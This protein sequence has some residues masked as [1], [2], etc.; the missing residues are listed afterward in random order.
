MPY[1]LP[2]LTVPR[3]ASGRHRE[4]FFAVDGASQ[5]VVH[6]MFVVVLSKQKL[7]QTLV[8]I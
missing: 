3:E 2:N 7:K 5:V 8:D 1:V 6:V 4:F